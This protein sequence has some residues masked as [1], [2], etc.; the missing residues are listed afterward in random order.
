MDQLKQKISILIYSYRYSVNLLYISIFI[1][2]LHDFLSLTDL[3]TAFSSLIPG[4]LVGFVLPPLLC[5]SFCFSFVCLRSMSCDRCCLCLWIFTL[6][7]SFGFLYSNVYLLAQKKLK[8][9]FTSIRVWIFGLYA[10]TLS[11]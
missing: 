9:S 2:N 6:D 7:C 3:F 11:R 8:L 10:F 1:L 5:C 4:F